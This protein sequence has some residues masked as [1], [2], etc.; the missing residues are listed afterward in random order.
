MTSNEKAHLCGGLRLEVMGFSLSVAR[1]ARLGVLAFLA[2]SSA[3]GAFRNVA[4]NQL[5]RSH[6]RKVPG[7]E[8]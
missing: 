2:R 7:L 1:F 5:D 3:M 6:A 4:R 8:A